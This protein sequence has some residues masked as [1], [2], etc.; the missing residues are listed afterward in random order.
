MGLRVEEFHNKMTNFLIKLLEKMNQLQEYHIDMRNWNGM[1]S[2]GGL[3]KIL[4]SKKVANKEEFS[5]IRKSLIGGNKPSGK[6][7]D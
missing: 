7:G 4:D 1:F 6:E 2:M 3:K 5:L